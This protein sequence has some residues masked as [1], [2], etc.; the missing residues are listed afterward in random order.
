MLIPSEIQLLLLLLLAV[1]KVEALALA[2]TA[3]GF[4][5]FPMALFFSLRKKIWAWS[6]MIS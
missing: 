1:A 5:F 4:A 2:E 6:Y 3:P